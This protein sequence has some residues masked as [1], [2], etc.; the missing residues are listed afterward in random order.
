MARDHVEGLPSDAPGR[1]EN[2][3]PFS[4]HTSFLLRY[5][6]YIPCGIT[7]ATYSAK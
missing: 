5:E 4:L 3:D 1:T 2:R 7:P 6:P